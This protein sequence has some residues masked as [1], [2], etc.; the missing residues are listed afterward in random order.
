MS[1]DKELALLRYLKR[2]TGVRI[3]SRKLAEYLDVS[4]RTIRNY[5][6]RI[7]ENEP[8]LI[9]SDSNGYQINLEKNY[10]DIDSNNIES[11]RKIYI[12]R[13]LIKNVHR[14]LDLY[15]LA[16]SLYISESTLKSTINSINKDIKQWNVTIKSRDF[17]IYIDGNQY[18]IR[19]LLLN[20]L[21]QSS[22]ENFSL[23]HEIQE[24]LGP[25]I[26]LDDLYKICLKY[27]GAETSNT[28]FL[29]NLVFHLSIALDRATTELLA[30]QNF[31]NDVV[32]EIIKE[33]QDNY[34]LYFIKED[35]DEFDEL[36]EQIYHRKFDVSKGKSE[37]H[38]NKISIMLKELE[39]VYGISFENEDFKNRLL[40][41][42]NSLYQRAKKNI[43]SRNLS[44]EKIKVK[45]PIL[46]DIAVYLASLLE[47]N[48]NIEVNDDEIAFLALHIGAFLESE[49]A[50]SNL[51]LKTAIV[52]PGYLDEGTQIANQ[53]KREFS[54]DL[55]VTDVLDVD[56]FDQVTDSFDLIIT[57]FP[58]T[59]L[60]QLKNS[61]T[62]QVTVHDSILP[63]EKNELWEAIREI[64]SD[65]YS[66]EITVLLNKTLKKSNFLTNYSGKTYKEALKDISDHLFKSGSV[67]KK[68]FEQ[69]TEREQAS[70][71]SFPSG[72][73]IP[74]TLR[75]EAKKTDVAIM[76]PKEE[77]QWG[78]NK[79]KLIVGISIN[80]EDR[81]I[82]NKVFQRF[83][84]II[85]A[86]ENVTKLSKQM[87]LNEFLN[88]L[89]QLMSEDNYYE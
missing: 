21:N 37:K 10:K 86:E 4:T 47:K 63:V 15:D 7:N 2:N 32:E 48:L 23:S 34:S 67:D 52:T 29:K 19:H 13:R 17:K 42:I 51:R 44:F 82:F 79:V 22:V 26:K 36:F 1:L 5:I 31:S 84:E 74:H 88:L 75:M 80:K 72:I 70:F 40:I 46:F 43:F 39:N 41:H 69:L 61:T 83:V 76:I 54:N 55:L 57:N 50:S 85:S 3:T 24:I 45:Y 28:F 30:P 12:L 6:K 78:D 56:I 16:D 38:I 58:M 14:G 9:I 64:K 27:L 89:I 71:T 87:D 11:Q 77:I 60:W 53:I 73:A 49:P 59:D 81:Q 33:I 25:N 18:A 8:N 66:E 65:Y 20:I 68:Y 35:L 62:K